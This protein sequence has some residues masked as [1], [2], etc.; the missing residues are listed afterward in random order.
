MA[1]GAPQVLAN[2]LVLRDLEGQAELEAAVRLQEETWGEG[3][4]ERVPA[5]I[6]MVARKVG[7]VAAG[8][9]A[10]GGD[11]LGFVFGITG[12]HG[13]RLVHWSDLLAVRREHRGRGL[14]E[15]LKRYQ[16]ERCRAIG[17]E[18]MHWTF[19]PM[20]ARNARLNLVRLGARV[21][22]FVVD[23]YGTRTGSPLHPLGTDRFVVNWPVRG[24]PVPLPSDPALLETVSTGAVAVRVPRDLGA[25]LAGDLEGA[26][27]WHAAARR[28]LAHHLGRG[29][30]VSAF[31]FPREG[32][33][34]YVLSPGESA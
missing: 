21:D 10:P 23:M 4:Q 33:P 29:W 3:F 2:G 14:G 8:A 19:D 6:L 15:A 30:R 24:E 25:L 26:R 20:A 22:E 32:D 11:L 5:S 27:A 12:V 9:F 1:S 18:T 7:G 13:G 16:R 31:V 34:A 17:V 28:A